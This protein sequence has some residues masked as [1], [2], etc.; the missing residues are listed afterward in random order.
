[1]R[2]EMR[3]SRVASSAHVITLESAKTLI[4][5]KQPCALVY[6]FLRRVQSFSLIHRPREACTKYRKRPVNVRA[7]KFG[8]ER[9]R[10]VERRRSTHELTVLNR[11]TGRARGGRGNREREERASRPEARRTK[12]RRSSSVAAAAEQPGSGVTARGGRAV[13]RSR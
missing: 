12:R 13:Q 4:L 7:R 2:G 10:K 8:A 9:A 5:F 1:M 6:T 11:A 3:C